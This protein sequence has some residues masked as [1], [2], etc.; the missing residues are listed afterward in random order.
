[1]DAAAYITALTVNPAAIVALAHA[2]PSD[3]V[4]WRPAPTE[5]SALEVVNHLADEEREDFRTRLDFAL[6]RRGATPPLNDP[7]DWAVARAYNQRDLEESLSRFHTERQ[8]SLT[9]LR[10][11]TMADWSRSWEGPSGYVL[12]AGDLLVA[13]AA[14]DLLHLRQLVELQYH[15]RSQQAIPYRVNYAGDW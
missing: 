7:A 1:M 10:G 3:Q 9:W 6:N 2:M 4:R 11:L 12:R 8:Q 15:C 13:W 14:H 5:W